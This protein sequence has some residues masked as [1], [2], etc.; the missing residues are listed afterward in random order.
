MILFAGFAGKRNAS[1]SRSENARPFPDYI[2]YVNWS[3]PVASKPSRSMKPSDASPS[4]A[5]PVALNSDLLY[6]QEAEKNIQRMA[7]RIVPVESGALSGSSIL[8]GERGC[9]R[10]AARALLSLT[11]LCGWQQTA[12][13]KHQPE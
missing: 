4:K 8:R 12:R 2:L 7:A 6:S 5:A 11:A 13:F 1:Q 3:I 9:R 10:R